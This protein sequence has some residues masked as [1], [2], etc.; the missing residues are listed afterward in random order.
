ME[1]LFRVKWFH[2][3]EL[4]ADKT[5]PSHLFPYHPWLVRSVEMPCQLA[6]VQIERVVDPYAGFDLDG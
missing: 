2:M 6:Y 4:V 1:S 5:Q 3:R